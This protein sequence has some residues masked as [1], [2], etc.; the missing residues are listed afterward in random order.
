MANVKKEVQDSV[1]RE[2]LKILLFSNE[3]MAANEMLDLGDIPELTDLGGL[4]S[5]SYVLLVLALED[6]YGIPLLDEMAAFSG[7][8]FA[9]LADFIVERLPKQEAG[10]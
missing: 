2:A 7:K 1:E 3:E 9:E 5:F 10:S 6:K 4:D 8:T